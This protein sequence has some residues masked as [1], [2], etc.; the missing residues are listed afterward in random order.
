MRQGCDGRW[1]VAHRVGHELVDV[2]PR[3]G[4]GQGL[5]DIG[6]HHHVL[7]LVHQPL[8]GLLLPPVVVVVVF[9]V[10]TSDAKAC[11][12]HPIARAESYDVLQAPRPRGEK[13]TQVRHT[14]DMTHTHIR[15]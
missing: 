4:R 12:S 5:E 9:V 15:T 2:G 1:I 6:G 8:K 11:V 3:L 14:Y 13:K 7:L 10:G